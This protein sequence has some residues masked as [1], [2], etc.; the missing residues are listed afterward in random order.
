MLDATGLHVTPGF[1][2]I[3]SHSD[4][5]L[6]ADPRAVSSVTQGVTFEVVGNCGHGCAPVHDPELVVANI[7][8]YEQ[9]VG[10][11]WRTM[12][13]YLAALEEARPAV[14]VASLVP[15]GN[16]RLAVTGLVDRPA[17]PEE[18]RRMRSLLEQSIEEGAIGYST[19]LEYSLER[20]CADEIQA[21]CRT[22]A[23][24]GGFY[25]TH[26]RNLEGQPEESI[27]EPIRAARQ[28]GVSLQISHISVVSRLTDESRQAVDRALRQVENARSQGIDVYFDMHTRLFGTTNLSAALPAWAVQGGKLAIER[29]LRDTKTRREMREHPNIIAALAR[30]DWARIVIFD[31]RSQPEVARRASPSSAPNAAR[32]PSTLSTICC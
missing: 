18:V 32:T 2:D 26:T 20:G 16:L 12:A 27:A 19:G 23:D 6:L 10:I 25:A 28:S 30:G 13:G 5:T 22:T 3:H 11:K 14:N 17:T 8:G 4:F 7:Y 29:R 24:R 1:I 9:A 15:N 21:L 31:S